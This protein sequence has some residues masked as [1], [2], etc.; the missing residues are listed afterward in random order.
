MIAQNVG[1][2]FK[3]KG[4][5]TPTHTHIAFFAFS[6]FLCFCSQHSNCWLLTLISPR[7]QLFSSA[8]ASVCGSCTPLLRPWITTRCL[9]SNTHGD[10]KHTN[11]VENMAAWEVVTGNI[12]ENLHFLTRRRFTSEY[13]LFTINPA[14]ITFRSFLFEKRRCFYWTKEVIWHLRVCVCVCVGRSNKI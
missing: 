3:R 11:D 5:N 7:C 9:R 1:S 4:Y 6:W 14:A 8:I 2:V 10:G 13:F 12:R